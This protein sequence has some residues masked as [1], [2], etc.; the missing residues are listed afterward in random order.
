MSSEQ[1]KEINT[2]E[3]FNRQNENNKSLIM[4]YKPN[5][6]KAEK[7]Q[8]I[9]ELKKNKKFYLDDEKEYKKNTIRIFGKHFAKQNKNKCKIT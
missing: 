2:Y 4:I 8:K 7:L 1:S 3:M 6:N 9:N 5:K